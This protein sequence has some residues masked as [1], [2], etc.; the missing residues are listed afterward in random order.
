VLNLADGNTEAW[1]LG[2]NAESEM[3]E[4]LSAAI[5]K[6]IEGK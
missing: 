2:F 1:L 3:L 4:R 5:G 6:P